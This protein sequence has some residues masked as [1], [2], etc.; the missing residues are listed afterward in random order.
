[1]IKIAASCEMDE[2]EISEFLKRDSLRIEV[3]LDID[4]AI[5]SGINTTPYYFINYNDERLIVPGVFEK[6]SFKIAFK[7]LIS[8]EMKN[9]TFL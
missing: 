6:E 2:E 9:K 4:E 8:G 3:D 5:S 1:M 7:D